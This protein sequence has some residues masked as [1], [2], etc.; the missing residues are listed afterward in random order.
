MEMFPKSISWLGMEKLN[1]TQQKHTYT[2]QKKYST[3]KKI[4]T[5][6]LQPGLV[7]S[8]NIQLGNGEGL[9]WFRGFTNLS[10]TYLL[11]YLPTYL[12]PG[13]TWGSLCYNIL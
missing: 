2:N 9:F 4:N 12:Q 7:V 5:K 10:L 8:Y 3:R 6:K 11:R 1:L 13:P